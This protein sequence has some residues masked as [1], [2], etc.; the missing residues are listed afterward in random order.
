MVKLLYP[1]NNLGLHSTTT[2]SYHLLRRTY[3]F[4]S[5][6]CRD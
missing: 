4:F 6:S 1:S 5:R 2:T 3:I